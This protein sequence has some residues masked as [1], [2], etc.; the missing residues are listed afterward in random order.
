MPIRFYCCFCHQLL[1]IATRKAGTVI[2][3]PT[4]KG[5]VWVPNPDEP[6]DLDQPPPYLQPGMQPPGGAPSLSPGASPDAYTFSARQ[7]YWLA[8]LLAGAIVLMFSLGVW[9]GRLF[10]KA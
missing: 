3:C 5:Q 1:G 9:V 2:E 4:C 10:R 6:G 8:G 7:A